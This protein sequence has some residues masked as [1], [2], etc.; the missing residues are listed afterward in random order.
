MCVPSES[1]I[2]CK[3]GN[4]A[5]NPH[6][7]P[8]ALDHLP[9]SHP[10]PPSRQQLPLPLAGKTHSAAPRFEPLEN[11][12]DSIVAA[13]LTGCCGCAKRV[14]AGKRLASWPGLASCTALLHDLHALHAAAAARRQLRP[15]PAHS[16]ETSAAVSTTPR[17]VPRRKITTHLGR[18][19][20]SDG[21][22]AGAS[23][24]NSRLGTQQA[25]GD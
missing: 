19:K 11:S 1:C 25:H 21:A 15:S 24:R 17:R 22:G 7:R 4:L 16:H 13:R 2:R 6:L 8:A 10:Q 20:A 9:R 14:Y 18:E 12:R 23:S 5:H 3:H